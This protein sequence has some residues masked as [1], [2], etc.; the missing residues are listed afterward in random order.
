MKKLIS[1]LLVLVFSCCLVTAALAAD[2]GD[3]LTAAKTLYVMGLFSGTGTDAGGVPDFDLDKVPTRAEAVTMLVTLLGKSDAAKAGTWTTPFT[4]VP[5]WAAPYVGYAYENGL[6][7]GLSKTLFG[8][9]S[10]ITGQQYLTLVLSALGYDEGADFSWQNASALADKLGLAG[11]DSSAAAEFLRGDLAI[12]SA[13]ALTQN[14][15]GTDVDLTQVIALGKSLAAE[16]DADIPAAEIAAIAQTVAGSNGKLSG[17]DIT[18]IAK[19]VAAEYDAGLPVDQIA[20]IT[21]R[22]VD[23]KGTDVPVDEIASVVKSVTTQYKVN[24]PVDG[25]VSIYTLISGLINK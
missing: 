4:D 21:V 11:G 9:S 12:I 3:A 18:A 7:A 10:P 17:E 1:L 16:S 8:S 25:A 15:K 13:S 23:S 5:A 6:T 22:L 20:S 24:L 2:S 14:F 19:L